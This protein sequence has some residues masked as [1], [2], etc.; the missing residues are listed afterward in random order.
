MDVLDEPPPQRPKLDV[1]MADLRESLAAP[2]CPDEGTRGTVADKLKLKVASD[3]EILKAVAAT[4]ATPGPEAVHAAAVDRALE[5]PLADM[6]LAKLRL[7]WPVKRSHQRFAA[8]HHET[9]PTLR[10]AGAVASLS[11]FTRPGQRKPGPRLDLLASIGLAF[12]S[13]TAGAMRQEACAL[14]PLRA[15]PEL[16]QLLQLRLCS[17]AEEDR[18]TAAPAL[19]AIITEVE[20]VEKKLFCGMPVDYRPR[21]V[22]QSL[23]MLCED[24]SMHS[25][26][27]LQ[28]HMLLLG[29]ILLCQRCLPKCFE[30]SCPMMLRLTC[31]LEAR[32]S[33][34]C[35]AGAVLPCSLM[36]RSATLPRQRLWQL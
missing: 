15:V 13:G 8:Q 29:G 11:L 20:A 23:T 26:H 30:A 32:M 2:M 24:G 12:L 10:R 33:L 19:F 7:A 21:F 34:R 17:T 5:I 1:S 36:P 9:H 18:T 22:A 31:P 4:L 27:R 6:E 25:M 16:V 3:V 28:L 35:P 14:V